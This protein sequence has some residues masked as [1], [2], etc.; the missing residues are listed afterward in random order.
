M[1]F[2]ID[3]EVFDDTFNKLVKDI[4]ASAR[5]YAVWE[6]R[7]FP[8]EHPKMYN[9]LTRETSWCSG[10]A[11]AI[12]RE[13]FEQVSGFDEKIFMYA[14]DVDLSWRIRSFGYKLRYTPQARIMHYAYQNAGEIKPTQYVNSILNNLLLRERFGTKK[15]IQ[16]GELLYQKCL[17][18]QEPYKGARTQL[19][20]G[21]NANIG[22]KK[23]FQDKSKI[24]DSKE[25]KPLFL[26]FDY[27]DRRLGDFYYNRESKKKPLVSVIVRTCGRP[28]VLRETLISLRNQTYEN[29]EII[30]VEDG[31]SVSEAMIQEEFADLNIIYRYTGEKKEDQKPVI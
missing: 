28:S 10:A 9:P 13:V 11:F 29:F 27:S 17:L 19:K 6:L 25:F 4:E 31:Q 7:Q 21:Y 3:T 5:E 24:G 30:I 26:G 15:D 14:E 1:F 8:Y 22:L 2:N 20:N 16:E 12:R 18:G 23:A